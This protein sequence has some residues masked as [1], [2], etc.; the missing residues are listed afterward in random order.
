[1]SW[2][3][4]TGQQSGY[5]QGPMKVVVHENQQTIWVTMSSK[6]FRSAPE[7]VRP[8]TSE[9]ARDIVWTPDEPNISEIAKQLPRETTG[10]ITRFVNVDSSSFPESSAVQQ[11]RTRTEPNQNPGPLSSSS[12]IEDQPDQEPDAPATPSEVTPAGDSDEVPIPD[13][14]EEIPIP[15]DDDDLVCEGLCCQDIDQ[16]ALE[17]VGEGFLMEK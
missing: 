8:V 5:W 11:D 17:D 1:M 2:R 14:P 9:E 13:K 4:G 3:E 10:N 15:N 16:N 7:H 6:L 12:G